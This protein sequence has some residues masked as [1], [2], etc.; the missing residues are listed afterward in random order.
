[1]WSI[2]RLRA[3]DGK[4]TEHVD[5]WSFESLLASIPPFLGRAYRAIARPSVGC[6][7]HA[8]LGPWVLNL[9]LPPKEGP[10]EFPAEESALLVKEEPSRLQPQQTE[11]HHE[12]R[13]R[14]TGHVPV[15]ELAKERQADAAAEAVQG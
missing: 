10:E 8:T 13:P 7:V 9:A 15:E 2:V 5:H 14:T 4:I 6:L 1:M 3:S 12:P 11:H